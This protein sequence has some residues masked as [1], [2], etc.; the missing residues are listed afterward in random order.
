M[1]SMLASQNPQE[2]ITAQ[3][4]L[5]GNVFTMIRAESRRIANLR[6]N[7]DKTA[8][9][10]PLRPD[11]GIYDLSA[12]TMPA[13]FPS[14]LKV[15]N[16]GLKIGGGPVGTDDFVRDFAADV[17]GHFEERLTALPGMN[18]QVGFGLLRV[19][20]SSAPVHLAQ[21]TPPLLTHQLFVCS[22]MTEW[23]SV[24]SSY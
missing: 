1:I 13:D 7:M 10:L 11:G 20:V 19:S 12:L 5:C 2:D 14:D 8:C 21:L 3:L 24:A 18:P 16:T 15:I 22:S 17:L 9:L 23:R 4:A 6:V